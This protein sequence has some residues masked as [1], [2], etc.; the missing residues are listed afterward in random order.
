M[1]GRPRCTEQLNCT[2]LL[3]YFVVVKKRSLWMRSC[4]V[5]GHDIIWWVVTK[6]GVRL[7]GSRF[8]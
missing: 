2:Q 1:F 7:R 3:K 5:I 8:V 4:C 6:H